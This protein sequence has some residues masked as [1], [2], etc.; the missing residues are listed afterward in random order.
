M[1]GIRSVS[2]GPR[3]D[4]LIG[5]TDFALGDLYQPSLDDLFGLTR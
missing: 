2:S 1:L 5:A 3:Y 4:W